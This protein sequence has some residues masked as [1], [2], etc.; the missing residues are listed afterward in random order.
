MKRLMAAAHALIEQGFYVFPLR[1][2]DKRPLPHFK[3]WEQRATRDPDRVYQWWSMAPYN[4]G[5][6]TGPSQ[7]LVVDC[8]TRPDNAALDWRNVKNRMWILGQQLPQTFSVRT[9]SSGLHLYF[10][11][12]RNMVLGNTASKLGKHV[13]TRGAGGYVVGPGSVHS[14]RFYVVVDRF[15]IAPLPTWITE[16]LAPR[17]VSQP[18]VEGSQR[19][20]SSYL[21]AILEG[22][23]ERVRSAKPGT[24]NHA[25]NTAAFLL[26]QLVGS[27]EIAEEYARLLLRNAGQLHIGVKGFT[28]AELEQTAKSGLTAG[29]QRPRRI[30]P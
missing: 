10:A 13:D 2:G 27:G 1:P 5:V 3:H 28:E 23:A 25:L 11:A 29:M 30:S 26:G 8:D 7:L 6:A 24:R 22:E 9:P 14:G 4:I 16:L 15:P 12:P 20:S 19:I 18:S 21:R 17:Q